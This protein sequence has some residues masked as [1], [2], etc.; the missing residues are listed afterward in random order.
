MVMSVAKTMNLLPSGLSGEPNDME[1]DEKTSQM[2][3]GLEKKL[4][5]VFQDDS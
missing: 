1:Q 5:G 2:L 4:Q 3:A